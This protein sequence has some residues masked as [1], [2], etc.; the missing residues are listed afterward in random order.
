MTR[1]E[2]KRRIKKAPNVYGKV[3]ISE[4]DTAMMP[5]VKRA[6]YALIDEMDDDGVRQLAVNIHFPAVLQSAKAEGKES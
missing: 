3:I 4:D 6:V 2:L 1:E 5:L